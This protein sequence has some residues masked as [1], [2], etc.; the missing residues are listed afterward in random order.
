MKLKHITSLI[1]LMV[2]GEVIFVLPFVIVRIFRPTFLSVFEV[3]NLELG[4]A[5]SAYGVV[6]M[7]AYFVGGPLADRFNPRR[8]IP[9]A[10]LVTAAGGIVMYAIPSVGFLSILYGFWGASTILLFWSAFIKAQRQLGIHTGQ[11]KSF[12]L[13]DAGRGLV[14]ALMATSSVYLLDWFLPVDA[15]IAT[16]EDYTIAL[17]WIIGL[18]AAFTAFCALIAWSI[19]DGQQSASVNHLTLKGVRKVMSKKRIWQ[20][21]IIVMCAYVGYKCTDDFSL[22][23]RDTLD[24]NDVEAAHVAAITFWSRPVAA[25]ISG[26]VADRWITS[27]VVS[28]CFVITM[29]GGLVISSGVFAVGAE[30]VVVIIAASTSAAIYGLRGIYYALF[31]ESGLAMTVT[32]SAAGLVSVVGYTPDIFMGPLMGIILDSNPGPLGHQ[33]LFAVLAGFSLVGLIASVLFRQNGEKY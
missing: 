24:Y 31:E 25:I 15:D 10:L 16:Q 22:Y 27:K 20:Q 1:L 17:Q 29:I 18:F 8:L 12:G 13:V 33:Y 21:A 32:G 11:G 23:A 5:F 6:A 28:V 26:V 2:I 3:T 7:I 30:I 4:T 19:L 14:A 9:T